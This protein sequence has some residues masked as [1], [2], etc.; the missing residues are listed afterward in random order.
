MRK[1]DLAGVNN[2]SL[3]GVYHWK[4]SNAKKLFWD[5]I[6]NW[7][8]R[9]IPDHPEATVVFANAIQEDTTIY[10]RKDTII[11][12]IWFSEEKFSYT[13]SPEGNPE[14]ARLIFLTG[15]Q[16]ANIVLDDNNRATHYI[17]AMIL[18]SCKKLWGPGWLIQTIPMS[19]RKISVPPEPSRSRIVFSGTIDSY[20]DAPRASLNLDGYFDVEISGKNKFIGP[21]DIRRGNLIVKHSESIPKNSVLNIYDP[22]AVFLDNKVLAKVK[23]LSINGI[24][25]NKGIYISNEADINSIEKYIPKNLMHLEMNKTELL[26]GS[27]A[28]IV[29]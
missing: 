28:I 27:G 17:P 11:S 29:S 10:L 8:E 25:M 5:D 19:E 14:D 13:I 22:G 3:P 7:E 4:G 20:K 26:K 23:E 15:Q 21:I 6:E 12:N 24:K 18:H 16:L 1:I 2:V 9:K